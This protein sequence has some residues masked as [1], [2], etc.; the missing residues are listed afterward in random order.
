MRGWAKATLNG[1]EVG[2]PSF[3][4]LPGPSR[5]FARCGWV[6]SAAIGP[7]AQQ[8]LFSGRR[9]PGACQR[10]AAC[11]EGQT[12]F[13]FKDD[14]LKNW[15][16]AS[17]ATVVLMSLWAESHLPMESIDEEEHLVDFTRPTVLKMAPDDRYFVEGA[18]RVARRAGRVVLRS[19]DRDA[20]L[21]C[22]CRAKRCWIRGRHPWHEQIVRLRA[23]P[24]TAQFVEHVTFA[25]SRLPTASGTC[26]RDSRDRTA[27]ERV[28][29]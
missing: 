16:D 18:S 7:F 28:G 2:R 6:G 26:P 15:P 9:S 3:P 19:Q 5:H 21:L 8:G 4:S 13:K 10:H 24:A 17:D 23:I 22:R 25:G 11:Q 20:L 27:R 12:R 14:D 1:H 29:F